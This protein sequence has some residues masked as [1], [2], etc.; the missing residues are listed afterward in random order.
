MPSERRRRRGRAVKKAKGL[1][2]YPCR[3]NTCFGGMEDTVATVLRSFAC[4][5][6]DEKQVNLTTALSVLSVA[7][8]AQRKRG[9]GIHQRFAYY[10]HLLGE[11]CRDSFCAV[12]DISTPTLTVYR[13]R[14]AAGD[15]TIARHG[16]A[17]NKNAAKVDAE[18][19]ATWFNELA[20][21][22]GE[23]VPLRIRR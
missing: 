3:K 9:K 1:C 13:Y 10:L 23:L 2:R 12:Y 6:R 11:V 22:Q 8:T 18:W 20:T 17:K 21:W 4:V 19:I 5:S 7:D 16:L 14:I 15:L